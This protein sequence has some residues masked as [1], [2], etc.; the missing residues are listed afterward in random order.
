VPRTQERI[1]AQ[2]AFGG[3]GED[4]DGGRVGGGDG[5]AAIEYRGNTNLEQ[6]SDWLTKILVGV[7]LT[8][9]REIA[10]AVRR[11]VDFLA[12]AFTL[13]KDPASA[14]SLVL[15]LLVFAPVCGFLLSYILTRIYFAVALRKADAEL[16][17]AAFR[18]AIDLQVIDLRR[19]APRGESSVVWE[20]PESREHMQ[21]L[22]AQVR[23]LAEEFENLR[24]A[25]PPG[26]E[27]T[28]R[29][30]SVAA[31]MRSFALAPGARFLPGLLMNSNSPGERLAAIAILQVMPQG[32]ALSWLADRV[33]SDQP[34]IGYH[35]AL[36]LV[37]AVRA[38][39]ENL[40]LLDDRHYLLELRRAIDTAR[41]SLGG[42]LAGT[43]RAALVGEAERLLR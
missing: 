26:E 19:A 39:R 1:A 6:I 43:D 17:L 21:V 28:R 5:A 42:E 41:L 22:R 12:P 14:Q 2:S 11:L 33:A 18:P 35:A 10:S 38:F 15:A 3:L 9:Y 4:G 7:S 27:R 20:A 34:F 32:E 16:S 24:A 29:C 25:L 23:V 40:G 31:Q 13:R 37:Y 30:E 8:Q 36:A